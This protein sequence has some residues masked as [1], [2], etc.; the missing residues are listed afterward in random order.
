MLNNVERRMEIVESSI[1]E[2]VY[3]MGKL[4]CFAYGVV[5]SVT[6]I[7]PFKA[8]VF[9][10]LARYIAIYAEQLFG[11]EF[12]APLSY[13]LTQ[14]TALIGSRFIGII[15]GVGLSWYQMISVMLVTRLAVHLFNLSIL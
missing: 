13:I 5:W 1:F 15:F 9:I 7:P 4:F 11:S 2:S 8:A 14:A 12:D 3:E 10:T 6:V